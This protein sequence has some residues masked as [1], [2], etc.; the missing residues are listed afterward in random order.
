MPTRE[1]LTDERVRELLK[2][3]GN[4][5]IIPEEE[6]E[7]LCNTR[8]FDEA[9]EC[10]RNTPQPQTITRKKVSD[11]TYAKLKENRENGDLQGQLDVLVEILLG[12]KTDQIQK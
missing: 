5:G 3:L 10:R 2:E 6:A 7:D 11:D 9:K 12:K 8:N 4:S 1:Q